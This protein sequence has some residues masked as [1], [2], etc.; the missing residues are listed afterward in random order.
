MNPQIESVASEFGDKVAA[1]LHAIVKDHKP[2]CIAGCRV[3]RLSKSL[4]RGSAEAVRSVHPAFVPRGAP[5]PAPAETNG[6][7]NGAAK[8]VASPPVTPQ[9]G[10]PLPPELDML[11]RVMGPVASMHRPPPPA[12][13]PPPPQPPPAEPGPKRTKRPGWSTVDAAPRRRENE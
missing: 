12:V 7:T 6:A 1:L 11:L 2:H 3:C 5:P 8:D 13:R 9:L 10:A 4:A